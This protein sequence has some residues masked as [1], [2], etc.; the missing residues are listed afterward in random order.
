MRQRAAAGTATRH[1][2]RYK[3]R[4][5]GHSSNHLA[6]IGKGAVE[7][8]S[9]QTA[10]RAAHSKTK[11]RGSSM[12]RDGM[13]K[14]FLNNTA[15]TGR[16]AVTSTED[17]SDPTLRMTTLLA[18]RINR[19]ISNEKRRLQSARRISDSVWYH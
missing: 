17:C 10:C 7:L 19:L 16:W 9:V 15:F 12:R 8:A 4:E 3:L 13:L 6:G 5:V 18:D 11:T 1:V 14:K 2:Q